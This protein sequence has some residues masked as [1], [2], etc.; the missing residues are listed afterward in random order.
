MFVMIVM[1]KRFSLCWWLY[2]I[3]QA[4]CRAINLPRSDEQSRSIVYMGTLEMERIDEGCETPTALPP[5][6]SKLEKN[7]VM[8]MRDVVLGAAVVY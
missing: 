8:K 3:D 2:S 1:A 7:H 5:P 4:C 6:D